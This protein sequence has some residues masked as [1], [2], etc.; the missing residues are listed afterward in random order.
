MKYANI[1]SI[2]KGKG[3]KNDL[4]NERGIFGINLIR[5]LLLKI[6][7]TDEYENLDKN[8]SDSNVG[9][10]KRKNIR[11][12]L[13]VV[14]GIINECIRTGRNIDL[15]ILDYKQ[16]FDSMWLD[17]TI[18]DLYETG[19]KNDNLNLI[20]KLNENNKVAVVTPHGLTERVDINKI[21]MQG[22]NL[23]PL[24]CSVQIDTFGKECI[25]ENKYLFF[26]R[27]SV[28]VPPLSMVDDLL[29]ISDC[30]IN[31]LMMNSFINAKSNIKKLQFG[32]QK[33]HKIHVGKDKSVCPALS[34][35][36][37]KTKKVEALDNTNSSLEDV[38]A[39]YYLIEDSTD[40]KYLGDIISYD[41]KND[42]NI[43]ERVKKGNGIIRQ[44][45]SILEELYF[46]KH[47]FVV[48]KI[49][50]ESLFI[51]SILLNSEVWYNMTEK[52][53]E[54]LEKVDNI[55]LRKFL[56]V[57][58]SVPTAFLHLELGTLPLRF[59]IKIR[60]ILYLQ[61]VLQEDEKS[62][63]FKFLNAQ[64]E[65]PQKGDWWLTVKKDIEQL[66]L[67]LSLHEIKSMSKESFK[68]LVQKAVKA[69]AFNWLSIKKCKSKKVKNVPH[70]RL[71]IQKYLSQPIM[72]T[73]ETKF[74]FGLRSRMTY[75][76]ENYPG[77]QAENHC[78]LCSSS[79]G[80]EKF[81]D[82]QEHLLVCSKLKGESEVMEE[83]LEHDDIHSENLNV[84]TK[85]TL[86]LEAKYNERKKLIEN[87]QNK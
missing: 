17:E 5:S 82:S 4:Q 19:L 75:L 80:V 26:Y 70:G 77:M 74:L 29:C 3:A 22:E 65:E 87:M 67:N 55:L 72:S 78:P 25:D 13:F 23:A 61:L 9:G 38:Q 1:T 30:G 52:N 81:M 43:T 48:A 14:N 10:R 58:Q 21:V 73:K 69:E 47:Y 33:C 37:W 83:Y 86:I 42:R 56:E 6:I 49:L 20:Y 11:N 84:Q 39:G 8:M 44:I 24:E 46:G 36:K 7:Y 50:R 41:G 16:C 79:S 59:I 66:N 32:E 12:H 64:M 35:D 54:D 60:R 62:L 45:S 2:Y 53:I 63:L 31:S 76:S 68:N 57:G 28:A 40:E 71:E 27:D 51:N 85:I 34:I 15:E 18:N